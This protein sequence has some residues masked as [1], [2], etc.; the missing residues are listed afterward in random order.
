MWIYLISSMQPAIGILL[1]SALAGF[2]ISLYTISDQ[3]DVD[4]FISNIGKTA[5]FAAMREYKDGKCR[6]SN[7]IIGLYF[8]AYIKNV[9][10]GRGRGKSTVIMI[11]TRLLFDHLITDKAHQQN[12]TPDVDKIKIETFYR[13]GPYTYLR[14]LPRQFQLKSVTATAP[15]ED[16]LKQIVDIYNKKNVVIAWIEGAPGCGKSTLGLL[17]AERMSGKLVSTFR[18]C[19]PGDTLANVVTAVSPTPSSPLIVILNEFDEDILA[20]HEGRV[21]RHIEISTLIHNK[22]TFN[23]FFD[24]VHMS[25]SN[26]II[27]M[28]SNKTTTF[29]SELDTSYLRAKRID[30]VIKL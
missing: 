29:I 10:G 30:L 11:C 12:I 13:D 22:G 16:A 19:D 23:D 28:T 6:P 5:H 27:L 25:Y 26:V 2:S 1:L 21:Q 17:L 7:I 9:E 20:V 14:Y 8:I 3:K 24:G 15:Q 4:V 18:P